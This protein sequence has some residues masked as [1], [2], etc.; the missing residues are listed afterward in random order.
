[1]CMFEYVNILHQSSFRDKGYSMLTFDKLWGKLD[2]RGLSRTDFRIAIG[3]STG[4]L[5]KLGK[6]QYVSLDVID[7]ICDYFDCQPNDIM[8]H[9]KDEQDYDEMVAYC[10]EH[11]LSP[12]EVRAIID[13]YDQERKI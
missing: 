5:A 7:K 9:Y 12:D 13:I 1:M 3:I 11:G 2:I 8:E 4:T 10:K 6:N